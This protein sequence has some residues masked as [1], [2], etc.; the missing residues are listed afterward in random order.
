MKRLRAIGLLAP[1]T[2]GTTLAWT[3]AA[4]STSG[5]GGPG[6]GADGLVEASPALASRF[7][8]PV[9]PD[10]WVPTIA[11]DGQGEAAAKRRGALPKPRFGAP[12]AR[13]LPALDASGPSRPAGEPPAKLG[14]AR[15]DAL[16][17]P[18]VR[19]D[20]PTAPQIG[21]TSVPLLAVPGPVTE[22]APARET[23]DPLPAEDGKATFFPEPSF[24]PEAR[25][26]ADPALPPPPP[27]PAGTVSASPDL[28]SLLLRLEGSAGQFA[29][30]MPG[31]ED[32][33][34]LSS[35]VLT[36]AAL[37]PE[38]V[39]TPAPASP[40][41]E[42][43][44]EIAEPAPPEA[45]DDP[46]AATIAP[47]AAPEPPP[48]SR[49]TDLTPGR[50]TFPT[51]SA[52]APAF[53]IDD[54]LILQVKVSGF[55]ATD[56]IVAF[57]TRDG[58]FL[59]LGELSLILDLAIRVS[60][61]GNYAS[62]WFLSE[63][64]TLTLDLRQGLVETADGS[65]PLARNLAQAF[66]GEL[67]VRSDLLSSLLPL[68]FAPNLRSQAVL[69]TTLEPFPFEE[70]MRREADR[71][72]LSQRGGDTRP[73]E[74]WPREETPWLPF[75]MPIGDVELRAVSDSPRGTRGEVDL[76]LAG[77]LAW[78]TAEVY[79]GATT[80]DGLVSSLVSLG[81]RDIDAELLGPLN[82]TEFRVG[83]VATL[84]MPMGLRGATGRGGYVTNHRFESY[85]VFDR[86]D[87]RGLLPDGY[88]VELYRNDVLLGSTA[89]AVNGQYEF[90]EV[91]VDYG[92]NVF[93]LVFYGPQGQRREEVRRLS[94]G[95][96]RLSPGELEYSFGAVQNGTNLLGVQGPEFRPGLRYGQWQTVGE[97]AYGFS[98]AL[99]GVA[100]AAFFEDEGRQRWLATA[101]VRTG[102]GPL[103]LRADIGTSDG[104]GHALGVGLGGPALGGAFTLS[105]FEYGGGF[106][107]EVRSFTS[108]SLR[109]ATELDF[110][111]TIGLASAVDGVSLPLNLRARRLEFADG[112]SQM[113]AALRASARFSGLLASNTLEFSRSTNPGGPTFTQLA[114][115][116]NLATF[117]RSRTQV[118]GSLG[119]R[120][121][122]DPALVQV[123]ADVHHALDDR[124]VVNA[125]AAYALESRE[126]TVG[127]S[128]VR[129]FERF[130][131]A[132]DGQYA[133]QQRTY[134]VALRLGF[135][136]GRDPLQDRFFITSPGKASSGAVALRAFQDRDGDLLYGPGDTA[137]PEVTFTAFNNTA[138]TDE[139]GF[140]RLGELGDGT[141]VAVQVDP[142]S[143][144]DIAMAPVNRGVEIVPRP[145]RFHVLDFPVVEVSEVEGTVTFVD[146]ANE[147]GVSGL[148][149]LLRG[150]REGA[151]YWTRTERGGYYFY[152][153]VMPGEYEVVI[154]PE[155]AAR[156]GIC[157]DA[158]EPLVVSSQGSFVERNL[159]VR[160]CE[161]AQ[162]A[163]S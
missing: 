111:T 108:Q 126:F 132:L 96:G 153:Q 41:E 109:R 118:R 55:D 43:A 73:R 39:L 160:V 8:L 79:L 100:S 143:L 36:E 28:D 64:R 161:Q 121:L 18:S 67:Y 50:Q 32:L 142:S 49:T 51:T 71:A 40:S 61:G 133:L 156:L 16:D 88:E 163:G 128:A 102:L 29:P 65:A 57:G 162:L 75:S 34:R 30:I 7:A 115:D 63:D 103:A 1:A 135:S 3:S 33:A 89:Q 147:R 104:G 20:L 45:A 90:L 77:D 78:M 24:G 129:E 83:D 23:A 150:A 42:V 4:G 127:V 19:L 145:G 74:T 80:S 131:L 47:E 62:G 70:R 140:A 35:P 72:R 122:P 17:P 94:V 144:P 15:L 69:L 107:D 81:R 86:I 151:E 60:D 113:N 158:G 114:G 85:S 37:A 48:Q 58:V 14:F 149:L 5:D 93:R 21:L 101:G 66:E 138:S 95:D 26:A 56:T 99:T 119:Y 87:L 124:T 12:P 117:N 6:S 38:A 137:L 136:F 54:E 91:P 141:P 146:G 84:P 139:R 105:H 11:V 53:T 2:L 125:S 46:P 59:P 155:Q 9:L 76:R 44:D 106:V 159:T 10:G 134:A 120:I 13:P 97:M 152:E 31:A 92:L 148:R 98:P 22:L 130:T 52:D 116:F 27:P 157:L 25:A 68:E 154:D 123:S 110:N 82:A 112:R